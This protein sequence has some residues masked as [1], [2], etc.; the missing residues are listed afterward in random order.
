MRW[1]RGMMVAG[2]AAL[3]LFASGIAVAQTSAA[4]V[5]APAAAAE[6]PT[7]ER[8]AAAARVIDRLW[9][10]GSYARYLGASMQPMMDMVT[11]PTR[12]ASLFRG[13]PGMKDNKLTRTTAH[14]AGRPNPR[15]AE[16]NAE[17]ERFVA[18]VEEELTPVL[19]AA[20]PGIRSALTASFARRYTDA[21][22]AE[23]DAFFATP[24]GA[25]YAEQSR[26]MMSEREVIDAQIAMFP[27]LM[28]RFP[29]IMRRL[30]AEM[31]RSRGARP[32]LPDNP[33]KWDGV[34]EEEE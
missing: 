2:V 3:A 27:D 12:L 31:R 20:E 26:T 22:L 1:N 8:L 14:Y 4:P 15:Q 11:D 17:V 18:I 30:T 29:A 10:E 9:P 13:A 23:L 16:M 25:L 21:Q 19:A 28:E 33:M 32:M 7:P 6:A 34:L 24:T 5:S